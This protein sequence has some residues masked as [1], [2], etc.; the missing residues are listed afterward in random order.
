[1]LPDQE[2]LDGPMADIRAALS[3]TLAD[4]PQRWGILEA[5]RRISVVRSACN[6]RTQAMRN[7]PAP[8]RDLELR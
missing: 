7:R 4:L 6:A 1:M 8:L 5:S 3:A 2:Y